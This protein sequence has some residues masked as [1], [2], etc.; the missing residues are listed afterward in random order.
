MVNIYKGNIIFTPTKDSFEIIENG[1]ICVENGLVL[2]ICAEMPKIYNDYTFTDF[3]NKLIVPGFTDLHVHAPQFP[4]RGLGLDE[5]LLLWLDKYTFPEEAKYENLYYA[6]KVY[7]KVAQLFLRY[8]TTRTVVFGTIHNESTMLLMDTLNT[9]KIPSFVGKVN[10]DRNSPDF[11]QETTEESL[12]KTI[13]W[14]EKT[15]AKYDFVKPI[16][17]PRFSPT[18]TKELMSKLG[19]IANK[20]KLAIQTHISENQDEVMLVKELHPEN[21]NYAQVYDE[22][23]LLSEKTI[24]AHCVYNTDEELAMMKEKNVYVAH[25][26]NANYNLASG[27]MPLRKFLDMNINVGLGTDIGAGHEISIPQVMRSVIQSSKI[28]WLNSNKT[29]SPISISEAFYLGTKSGG[30]FF[31]KVGSFEKGYEFDA[32]II[33]DTELDIGF[34]KT[35]QERIERFI[36]TGDDR[37]IVKRFIKGNEIA[38]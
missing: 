31:G 2:E 6:E 36:Y 4:N 34:E 18:C 29:L 24:L 23:N 14:I 30:S 3:E 22:C 8:G 19:E 21:K 11:L 5:Q 37:H 7:T 16:I 20:H 1:Y 32:L 17:T 33:D 25:C 9:F 10:M 26:P 27:I 28:A 15:E 12:Q 35:L 13:E 38:V